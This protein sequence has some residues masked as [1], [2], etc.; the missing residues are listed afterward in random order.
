MTAQPRWWRR[1]HAD[2]R[3]TS[4]A[5]L[6]VGMMVMGIFMAIFTGAVVSLARSTTKVE[7]VTTSAAQVNN[8][9]LRLDKV[10][11]YAN[12]ITPTGKSTGPSGD[13]YLE[14]SSVDSDT[15][16]ETCTQ[17]R[18]DVPAQALQL[19]TWTALS[20]TTYSSLSGW[21]T[22]ANNLTN[23]TAAAGAADQPFTSPTPLAAA[24]TSFQQLTVTLVAGTSGPASTSTT[25]TN[26]LFTA[27]NSSTKDKTNATKCQQLPAADYR[28]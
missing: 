12:A 19:R 6:L 15:D 9:F 4:L 18:A 8:A 24:S 3:G 11:R 23:T 5:E 16:V 22:L 10:V 1:L 21:S 20:P 26:V 7:A 28:P 27:L 14:L 25:R 2:D 17:L 13:W